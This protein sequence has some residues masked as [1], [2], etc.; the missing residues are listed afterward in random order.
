METHSVQQARQQE[1]Q[2]N[3][4]DAA[5][6]CHDA[7]HQA[8]A[9]LKVMPQDD[10]AGLVGEGAAARKHNAIGEVHGAQRPVRTPNNEIHQASSHDI[11]ES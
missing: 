4:E 9:L 8:Q 10:Q 2:G 7:V 6:G 3:G 5:A 1:R 11:S